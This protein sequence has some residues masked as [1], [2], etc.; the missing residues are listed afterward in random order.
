[1]RRSSLFVTISVIICLLFV[2]C[3]QA[4]DPDVLFKCSSFNGEENVAY[5]SVSGDQLTRVS[6]NRYTSLTSGSDSEYEKISPINVYLFNVYA[7]GSD[8]A[9]WEYE[10]ASSDSVAYDQEIL[11]RELEYLE[12]SY[13]GRFYVL[14]YEFGDYKT[15]EVSFR[16]DTESLH[17]LLCDEVMIEIPDDIELDLVRE[18]YLH[19]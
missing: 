9:S 12:I 19:K 16:D 7:E 2:S 5:Y 13:T 4:P 1:M 18:A 17:F 11:I 8:P 10:Q 14:I 3:S 15:L 6:E